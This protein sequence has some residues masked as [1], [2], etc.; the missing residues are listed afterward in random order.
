MKKMLSREVKIWMACLGIALPLCYF[1]EWESFKTSP[2]PEFNTWG[3]ALFSVY[4]S[5]FVYLI[6]TMARLLVRAV[7]TIHRTSDRRSV[8]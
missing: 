3:I 1:M 4:V 7:A 6:L 8:K 2:E 5:L